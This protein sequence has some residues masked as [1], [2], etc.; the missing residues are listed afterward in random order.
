MEVN[1][2]LNFSSFLAIHGIEN[3]CSCPYTLEQNG[4]IERKMRHIIE[5]DLAL[6]TNAPLP[7][8]LWLYALYTTIFLINHLSTKVLHLQS[9]F[10]VL[11]GKILNYPTIP[12]SVFFLAIVLITKVICVLI[13]FPVESISLDI[14]SFQPLFLHHNIQTI[15]PIP[16]HLYQILFK[17]L[18]LI[19]FPTILAPVVLP[20]S[21][22]ILWSLVQRMELSSKRPSC[23]TK[24]LNLVHLHRLPKIDPNW[25]L[26]IEKEFSTLLRNNAWQLVPAPP[27]SNI[28]GCK[29]DYKLKH[30]LDGTINHYK[31]RLVVKG[32]TQTLGLDYFG[33]FSP[34]VKA[35]TIQIVLA[36]ALSF[37]WSVR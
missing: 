14:Q 3:R 15:A 17:F 9:P 27:N 28:V 8:K 25:T 1:S 35:P 23:P 19:L 24:L 34:I 11:F 5:T 33:T 2:E 12:F 18:L 29:W 32:F 13:L 4:R 31:A 26:A 22:T 6:L 20:L 37:Q 36:I 16:L 21:I 7:L 10:Q 30:K